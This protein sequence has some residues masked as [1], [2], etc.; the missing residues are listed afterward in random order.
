MQHQCSMLARMTVVQFSS[1]FLGGG[2][3]LTEL[4][5][6][7]NG[8]MFLQEQNQQAQTRESTDHRPSSHMH[9]ERQW[10]SLGCF[11]KYAYLLK[12]QITG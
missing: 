6:V 2:G 10:S 5:V 1:S 4:F 9:K 12:K 11:I 3:G 7:N 8:A